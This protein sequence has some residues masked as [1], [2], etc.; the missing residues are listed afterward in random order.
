MK[1]I[2][3]VGG[4]YTVTM[5]YTGNTGALC[6]VDTTIVLIDNPDPKK[7]YTGSKVALPVFKE[8]VSK[9]YLPSITF[10]SLDS[11]KYPSLSNQKDNNLDDILKTLNLNLKWTH[12]SS[13]SNL[14][15]NGI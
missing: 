10:Q 9:M 14:Q 7:G 2:N 6:S 3:V 8:I 1:L 11:L 12:F 15:F 13:V 4:N 5:S